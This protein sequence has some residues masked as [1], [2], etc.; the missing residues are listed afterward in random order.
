MEEIAVFKAIFEILPFLFCAILMFSFVRCVCRGVRAQAV[1]AMALV[2]CASKFVFFEVLGGDAFAPE[3]TEGVI[4]AWGWAY[5]GMCLLLALSLAWHL[6]RFATFGR[7]P[8]LRGVFCAVAL[9]A[10]AWTIA[11]VG[12]WNG[13][14][15]PEVNEV[16]ITSENMPEQ[17]DGYRIVQLSD[18]HISAAAPRHRTEAIVKAANAARPDLI[19][20][21]GDIVD[22]MPSAQAKNVLPLKDLKANDGVYAVTGNHEFYFDYYGWMS[23]YYDMGLRFLS[24]KCVFPRPGL[25]LGGVDDPVRTRVLME[26]PD[27][28]KA[29]AS[30]TNGEFRIFMQHRPWFDYPRYF[31]FDDDTPRDLQ[32]SG[33]THGGIAPVLSS[34]I[35]KFNNGFVRG[36]YKS[37]GHIRNLYVS[38]GAGQWG[39]FPVRLFND[40]EITLFIL[41]RAQSGAE[42]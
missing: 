1:W 34:L 8:R 11:A 42:P 38:P 5:S 17:L 21:T 28:A 12:V 9:P 39:G 4:L 41:R 31:G 33:H 36:L 15:P 29:F 23:L 19:C 14:K 20:I 6:L 32:L 16:V 7:F 25:A 24:N 26:P 27:S 18:L 30:A 10:V 13:A 22:G 2:A 37:D 3:L 40:A 35:A